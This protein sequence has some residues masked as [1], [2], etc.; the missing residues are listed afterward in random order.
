LRLWKRAKNHSWPFSFNEVLE[1][2]EM[3]MIVD[4]VIINAQVFNTFTKKFEKKNV[5]I[6]EDKFSI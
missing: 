4:L 1:K 6:V 2:G 3:K 5:L